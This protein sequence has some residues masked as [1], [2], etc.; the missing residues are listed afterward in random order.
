MSAS[1]TLTAHLPSWEE[2]SDAPSLETLHRVI[3]GD[4]REMT[5]IPND[6]IH[7]IVTSPPYFDA[8]NYEVESQIGFGRGLDDYLVQMSRVIRECFRV[9]SPSRKF[10]LN[11]SDLPVKGKSGVRWIP[12]GPLLLLKCLETGFE[13]VDRVVWQKTPMKGFQYGS[14]PYPGSPLICDSMEYIYILRKPG[15]TNWAYVPKSLKER[16]KLTPQEYGPYTMQIWTIPRVRRK[17]NADG[18]VAPFPLELPLRCIK[19]YSFAG[20]TV[21]DPFGGSGT[22]SLAAFRTGRNS[23]LYEINEEYAD[24]IRTTLG[25]GQSRLSDGAHVVFEIA[26]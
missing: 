1:R 2:K 11:V 24:L 13:L 6:S 25:V 19:L 12:L 7:L 15:K 23:V 21:L 16:S 9:L 20:D 14:L 22:T 5:A 17:D 18:H 8:R 3:F 10:C 4:S 26:K